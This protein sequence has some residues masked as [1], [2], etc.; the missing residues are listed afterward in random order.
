MHFFLRLV[1]LKLTY[2][3]VLTVVSS[4]SSGRELLSLARVSNMCLQ[5]QSF[6]H[7]CHRLWDTAFST[8]RKDSKKASYHWQGV[9]GDN[10]SFNVKSAFLIC[11]PD[12]YEL[13]S[14]L[15]V[16]LMSLRLVSPRTGSPYSLIEAILQYLL[17][18]YYFTTPSAA[19][20]RP[21][22]IGR[23]FPVTAAVFPHARTAALSRAF[24]RFI[25]RH[26]APSVHV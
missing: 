23:Y 15:M 13:F 5:T 9:L 2:A 1:P 11:F 16:V 12:M 18:S 24:S 7:N 17:A 8:P 4:K 10:A 6:L 19:F 26:F 14:S 3:V 20:L 22:R 21:A 25:G